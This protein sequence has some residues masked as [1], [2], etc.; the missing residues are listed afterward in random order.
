VCYFWPAEADKSS[1]SASILSHLG[2]SLGCHVPVGIQVEAGLTR[3]QHLIELGVVFYDV[4]IF[5]L[6]TIILS[7]LVR[8]VLLARFNLRIVML[9]I[10][11]HMI[12]CFLQYYK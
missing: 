12:D 2:C 9:L 8:L 6:F 7:I 5:F 1:F 11:I 3:P 4:C 10:D